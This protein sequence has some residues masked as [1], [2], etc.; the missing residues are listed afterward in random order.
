MPQTNNFVVFKRYF[1]P[2]ASDAEFPRPQGGQGA[3]CD[4][5][6]AARQPFSDLGQRREARA[7]RSPR[8]A[9]YARGDSSQRAAH[10]AMATVSSRPLTR[11]RA[12]RHRSQRRNSAKRDRHEQQQQQV[13]QQ[14]QGHQQGQQRRRNDAADGTCSSASRADSRAADT[15]RLPSLQHGATSAP[16]CGG[17][18]RVAAPE[19]GLPLSRDNERDFTRYLREHQMQ[20]PLAGMG[21]SL[22]MR[23]A[24]SSSASVPSTRD[25]MGMG[26]F[27]AVAAQGM[28]PPR[29]GSA[30]AAAYGY[31]A[32][33]IDQGLNSTC[34][35]G[36]PGAGSG[37]RWQHG[38]SLG[39]GWQAR[40]GLGGGGG[41]FG[42]QFG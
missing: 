9:K 35:P 31:G 8:Q 38:R 22:P 23:A 30:A 33:A 12:R 34:P 4:G 29:H 19:L 5:E 13:Q 6:V 14:G 7:S 10:E 3:R 36:L 37:R 41:G 42:M 21:E 25:T 26:G 20:A 18:E 24:S 1:S 27:G 15:R 17:H 40:R 11:E 28:K 39:G 2:H 32:N 16:S